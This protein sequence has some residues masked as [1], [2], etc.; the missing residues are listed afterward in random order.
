MCLDRLRDLLPDSLGSLRLLEPSAGDGAFIR[1][2]DE[3]PLGKRVRDLVAVELLES[4]AQRC[5]EAGDR[6][7]FETEIRHGSFL[8][9]D[10]V[11]EEGFDAAVGN[12]P[13]VR[14]QFVSET[15][16]SYADQVATGMGVTLKGVSNLWI[17]IF[18]CA[19][20]KV[21]EGG[22]FAFIIPAE[23]LTGIS[24]GAVRRWLLRNC[25]AV[26]VD[27]FGPGSFP[28]VLQEVVVLSGRRDPSAADGRLTAWDHSAAGRA[29]RHSASPEAPTWTRYLLSPAQLEALDEVSSLSCVRSAG[30]WVRFGVATV[31][32]ANDYFSVDRETIEQYG[33]E[34]WILPLLPRIRNA[35]GLVFTPEDHERN[36]E[37]GARAGLI[38]FARG[39]ASPLRHDGALRYIHAGE[40]AELHTRYK[41]RIR[42]P[43]YCVPVVAAG[44]LLLSK[45]S[46]LYPRV[47]VNEVSAITTDTI[48]QGKMLAPEAMSA[49]SFAASFHN[50]LTLLSAEIEGRSFG[51]G[52]LELVP[53]EVARLRV[54]AHPSMS[55]E[56]DRLDRVSR[57]ASGDVEEILIR[58]TDGQLAKRIP[59]ISDSTLGLLAEARTELQKRRLDRNRSSAPL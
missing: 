24:A 38:D 42:E 18:L 15:E 17:P 57:S 23:C 45:R 39:E 29:W 58:E 51:G 36:I 30:S 31:T 52:V 53:S 32:G 26:R 41:C 20:N 27:L 22:A 34:D 43:W 46:H 40:Q 1:G 16:R 19:L 14:F 28:G 5:E 54:M 48:Y 6:A 25:S 55:E 2:L 37:E 11:P 10:L 49:R 56:L 8:D 35:E 21:R 3:D 50:S 47:V 33:L 12:P 9:P 7:S 4:E 59:Q 44:D 13:F